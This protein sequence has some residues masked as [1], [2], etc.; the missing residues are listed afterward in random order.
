MERL[1]REH[2]TT[3]A[4][5]RELEQE[6]ELLRDQLRYPRLMEAL[7]SIQHWKQHKSIIETELAG[8]VMGHSLAVSV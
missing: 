3:E 6:Y 7:S 8:I 4:K 1:R 2:K 5:L